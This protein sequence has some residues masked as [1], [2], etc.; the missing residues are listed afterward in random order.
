MQSI[1]EAG[2]SKSKLA[3]PYHG[4]DQVFSFQ[5]LDSAELSEMKYEHCIFVNVSFMD[6]KLSDGSFLDCTFIACY[7]KKTHI[8][9][10]DFIGCRFID[11]RFPRIRLSSCSFKYSTY[12]G[13]VLPY[14]EMADCLPSEQNLREDLCRSL[15]AESKHL[16]LWS[17]ARKY[18]L[19]ELRAY[20]KNL[21]KIAKAES[22][23]YKTHYDGL[24]RFI[25]FFN[26]LSCVLNRL[27]WGHGEK[28]FALARNFLII[29]L[30]VFPLLYF[31]NGHG[32]IKP[33]G[34]QPVFWD[35][36]R[37]SLHNVVSLSSVEGIRPES[38]MV[39]FLAGLQPF[40]SA[41]FASL[42]ASYAFRYISR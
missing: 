36:I 27:L 42:F 11:C 37:F 35:C 17:Q 16:G 6:C 34:M 15:H 29:V 21:L 14:E 20:E 24:Q 13:C 10:T 3:A 39:W 38:S 25:S 7:F 9:S 32:L 23:W 12:Q 33:D 30:L 1:Y 40:V 4:T 22:A 18:R 26:Y 19:E 8:S 28:I 41:I 2:K 31:L 5:R